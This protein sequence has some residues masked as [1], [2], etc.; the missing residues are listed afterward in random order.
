MRAYLKSSSNCITLLTLTLMLFTAGCE[1]P[2]VGTSGSSVGGYVH[3]LGELRAE[4]REDMDKLFTAV[5][6]AADELQYKVS[7]RTKDPIESR[8]VGE[9]ATGRKIKIVM[10]NTNP[11]RIELR[12]RVGGGD[13]ETSIMILEKIRSHL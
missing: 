5:E 6:T 1:M 4:Q 9:D 3:V 12:I 13:K 2:A 7:E 11:D 10:E 8:I